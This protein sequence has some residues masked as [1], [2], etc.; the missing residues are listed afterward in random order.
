MQASEFLTVLANL[1]TAEPEDLQ[2]FLDA[3]Q[4]GSS[5]YLPK[6]IPIGTHD[7]VQYFIKSSDKTIHQNT[8]FAT[9]SPARAD[10]IFDDIST[11]QAKSVS[12]GQSM[13]TDPDFG[14]PAESG[15]DIYG[16]STSEAKSVPIGQSITTDLHYGFGLGRLYH[17][18]SSKAAHMEDTGFHVLCNAVDKSIWV[19]FDFEPYGETGD[20]NPVQPEYGDPY[21]RLPGD[22]Q[23]MVIG[24]MRLF[25]TEWTAKNPLSLD[26][27]DP[28][29]NGTGTPLACRLVARP[30]FVANVRN[31]IKAGTAMTEGGVGQ[32]SDSMDV[33][34]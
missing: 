11:Y 24:I 1:N 21:G 22:K 4:A 9:I 23:N 31:A 10:D 18:S 32:G 8:A 15:D 30:A 34:V 7:D 14:S 13:T 19:A 6:P 17:K 29:G 16:I 27:G 2:D 25:G 33:L 12:G 3:T 5:A 26:G 20:I 28:F